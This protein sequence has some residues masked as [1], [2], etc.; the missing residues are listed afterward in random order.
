MLH[1]LT[2]IGFNFLAVWAASSQNFDIQHTL[3]SPGS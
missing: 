3:V 2:R 1:R